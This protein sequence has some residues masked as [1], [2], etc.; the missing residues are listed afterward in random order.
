MPLTNAQYDSIM[1]SYQEAVLRNQHK[2]DLHRQI[3]YQA[4]PRLTEIDTAVARSSMEALKNRFQKIE[5]GFS[6]DERLLE[7]SKERISC[8]R[9]AGLPDNY[10]DMT[11]DCNI[12]K[13]KGFI[14]NQKCSCFLQ[15][16]IE[17]LY[18]QSNIR[19]YI[20][21][22]GFD[23]CNLDYYSK[24]VI[25][26]STKMSAYDTAKKA[27][28]DSKSFVADFDT[29]FKNL[30][31]FGETGVGKTFFSLCIAKELMDTQHNVVYFTAAD[32]FEL[33][34]NSQFRSQENN[35]AAELKGNL[36]NCD[37]LI[38]DDLGTEYPNN[39]AAMQLY[40]CIDKRILSEKST[41][42]STN[43]SLDLLKTRYSERTF[44]RI[45]S[46]YTAI[47]LFGNDIRLQKK[48]NGG[49]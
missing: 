11:Y 8:L 22:F 44:S 7:L 19:T 45:I 10:L 18:N 21:D 38:I 40:Q 29:D 35:R 20:R 49:L 5:N 3:A 9:D 46:N 27:L 43:L 24:D 14:D 12:C 31:F 23:K 42:I 32:L 16:E 4:I 37:L 48:L 36:M 30:L 2:L 34:A 6:L 15:K 1:R 26:G 39:F 25:G 41:I 17:L 13:D 33:F 28:S 47:K